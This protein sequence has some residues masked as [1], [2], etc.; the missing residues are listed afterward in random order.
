M[1]GEEGVAL[2]LPEG[3][4]GK[5]DQWR[6][7]GPQ[8]GLSLLVFWEGKKGAIDSYFEKEKEGNRAEVVLRTSFLLGEK[9]I[10]VVPTQ[11]A[12]KEKKKKKKKKK[13]KKM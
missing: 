4:G 9:K 13:R 12:P 10:V 3:G 1:K 6:R 5:Q 11:P 7:A 2:P 8:G